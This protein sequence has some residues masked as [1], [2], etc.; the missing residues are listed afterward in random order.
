MIIVNDT[1]VRANRNINTCFLKVSVTLLTYLDKCC[2]LTSAYTLLLTGNADRAAADADLDEVCAAICEEAEAFLINNVACAD[3]YAVA[4][5]CTDPVDSQLLPLRVALGAV[6]TQ[7]VR[8]CVNE[9]RNTLCVIS[10][11]DTCAYYITLLAVEKLVL[12]FLMLLIVLSEYEVHK[13][14]VI[15]N[16]RKRIE[17][18]FPDYIVCF[19]ERCACRSSDELFER[20]HECRYL[21]ICSHS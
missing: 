9:S 6:D 14:A 11:V 1:A 4:V 3:L 13:N 20:G 16:Y 18:M 5:V 21:C 10:C 7:N 8:T 12:V 2:S 19:L 17:F 15:I